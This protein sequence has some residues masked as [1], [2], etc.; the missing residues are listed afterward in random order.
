MKRLTYKKVFSAYKKTFSHKMSQI[1][2]KIYKKLRL[3]LSKWFPLKE[4]ENFY[5][6]DEYLIDKEPSDIPKGFDKD[7]LK[8][9]DGR[10]DLKY[11]DFFDYLPK[12]EIDLFKD[13]LQYF[14]RNNDIPMFSSYLTKEDDQRINSMAKYVDGLSFSRLNDI[15]IAKNKYLKEYAPQLTISIHNLSTSFLLVKYRFYISDQFNNELNDIFKSKFESSTDVI[16][17]FDIPWF[18]PWKFGRTYYTGDDARYKAVYLKISKLKWKIFKEINSS[19]KLY[20]SLDQI[21]PPTF[22]TYRTNIPI[23]FDMTQKSFWRSI[24]RDGPCDYSEEYNLCIAWGD[25]HG[26]F[27]GLRLS[28]YCGGDISPENHLPDITEHYISDSYGVYMVAST[29]RKVAERDMALWNKEISK[30]IRKSKSSKLLKVRNKVA[31]KLYY[32][33]RFL[34]EFSGETIDKSDIT[35]FY[36]PVIK[37]ETMTSSCFNGITKFIHETKNQINLLLKLLDNSIEY[38]TSKSNMR[39]QLLMAIIT[40]ISL[41]VAVLALMDIKID[42]GS[43]WETFT[44]HSH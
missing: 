6:Q 17:R 36:N 7:T 3:W 8:E 41:I 34:N 12:E 40:I 11:L 42:F 38:R 31:L 26:E 29:M 19:F 33:Y 39:L 25:N 27:E 24:S 30:A 22:A 4:H 18:K 35:S 44:F 1:S 13:K 43:R 9:V 21:F 28:A 5:F 15:K 37:T 2:Y 16:R 32:L 14:V 10:I 20:F 23:S